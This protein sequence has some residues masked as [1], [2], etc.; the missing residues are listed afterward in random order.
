MEDQASLLSRLRAGD[1][2]ALRTLYR[3]HGRSVYEAAVSSSLTEEEARGVV[4][5]VFVE[6][7]RELQSSEAS[8]DVDALIISTAEIHIATVLS[9]RDAGS[10]DDAQAGSSAVPQPASPGAA[11]QSVMEGPKKQ[12]KPKDPA[13]R[14]AVL[15]IIA[16]VLMLLPVLWT[17]LG[18]L[19][20]LGLLPKVDLGHAAFDR[21][22][23]PLFYLN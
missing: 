5:S 2:D 16:G 12:K 20:G 4:K 14:Q 8:A 3:S 22:I 7:F 19:M 21:V 17:L 10:V 1:E 15:S 11:L 9:E 13:R 18:T 6:V 23:F